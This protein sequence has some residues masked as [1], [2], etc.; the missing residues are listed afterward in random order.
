MTLIVLHNGSNQETSLTVDG[1]PSVAS[2]VAVLETDLVFG[3]QGALGE[4]DETKCGHELHKSFAIEQHGGHGEA[5]VAKPD[6]IDTLMFLVLN[7]R[8]C[9]L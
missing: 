7:P 2:L 4:G 5:N 1:E 3:N 9:V 8:G 6:E